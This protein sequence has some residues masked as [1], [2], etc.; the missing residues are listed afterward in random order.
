MRLINPLV[1]LIPQKTGINEV[2]KHIE[3]CGRV[4]YKSE[5][6]I[7]GD[8]AKVFI[9]KL[10][11]NNH[12]AVLEH[13]A[14]YL[15]YLWS[16]SV[17]DLCNQISPNDMIDFYCCNPYS[18]VAYHGNDVYITTNYRV[19]VEN[20]RLDDLQYLCD[21]T[22]H[23]HKRVTFK[24]TTDRAVAQEITR[25]RAFSFTMESQRYCNYSKDKFNN[26]VT[27]IIPSWSDIREGRYTSKPIKLDEDRLPINSVEDILM[28][29]F[30]NALE[31]SE[32]Q[33]LEL[34]NRGWSPQKARGVLPNATKTE[35]FITGF[36]K[37]WEH[38]F[39]LRLKGT[40]G[41]PHP[42]MENIAKIMYMLYKT[43]DI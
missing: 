9:N 7:E 24:L 36:E 13:G 15:K 28:Q 43:K 20:N 4:S 39:N 30:L 2:Y 29:G 5:D 41:K 35:L 23:H 12:L 6:K 42:D 26:E 22:E 14:I 1:A 32:E 27:F 25:H 11:N 21:P 10:I 37:D 34:L 3:L 8:S 31:Y 40:T 18:M 19:L 17:C 38:F 16:G 33:Y